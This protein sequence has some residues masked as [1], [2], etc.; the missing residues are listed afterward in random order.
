[1]S[2]L[3]DN[4]QCINCQ[5]DSCQ[6]KIVSWVTGIKKLNVIVTAV[7]IIEVIIKKCWNAP[8]NV[9]ANINE[10]FVLGDRC[11]YVIETAVKTSKIFLLSCNN[12]QIGNWMKIMIET[13]RILNE[14]TSQW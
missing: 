6:K 1:M 7:K 8:I 4:F 13:E 5:C 10:T 2:K 3:S 14:C 9:T 11:L 12:S